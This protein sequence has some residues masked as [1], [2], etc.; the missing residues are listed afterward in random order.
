MAKKGTLSV[1]IMTVNG[2]VDDSCIEAMHEQLDRLIYSYR[3]HGTELA[4]RVAP[5]V[6]A[7]FASAPLKEGKP[8][9]A[10][11]DIKRKVG[12]SLE[13]DG[14]KF[15]D[16]VEGVDAYMRANCGD[17]PAEFRYTS[18]HRGKGGIQPHVWPP[19]K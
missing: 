6:E 5:L 19:K 10:L 8:S 12:T 1:E 13:G 18:I 15:D 16:A 7:L 4:E 2:A 17:N 3:T 14:F 11:G 9:L